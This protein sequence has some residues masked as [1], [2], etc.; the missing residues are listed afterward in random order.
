MRKLAYIFIIISLLTLLPNFTLAECKN[1]GFTVVYI[2]GIFT[3]ETQAKKD[4]LR[5][6]TKYEE[7]RSISNVEFLNGYNES[8]IDGVGDLIKSIT[9][10]YGFG[11]LD[12]DLTNILRQ[13]NSELKTRKVLLVGHSQG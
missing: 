5:L 6:Q 8:H 12:Y 1:N 7:K 9:Q 2:N 10:A 4:L 11:G 13:V 3:S